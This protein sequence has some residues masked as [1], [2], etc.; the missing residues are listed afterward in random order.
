METSALTKSKLKERLA[1]L[2]F[3]RG[4]D[5]FCIVALEHIVYALRSALPEGSMNG[6][7]WYFE[8][9]EWEGLSP[10]DIIMPLFLFM[11]GVSVPFALGRHKLNG[12]G[13]PVYRRILRRFALLWIFGMIC[14]GN[15]LGL[16]PD[17]IYLYSN[18]LQAIAVGYLAST[19]IFLNF[20]W[21]TMVGIFVGLIAAFA[22]AMGMVRVG[23]YGGGDYT[24]AHNLAEWI[25]MQVLGR[26]RDGAEVVNGK[27]VVPSWNT[28]TWI[29]SSLTFMATTLSGTLC[30]MVLKS[31]A[32]ASKRKLTII[33]ASG[34]SM[35][36]AAY[37]ASALGLP[38][39][40]R[41]WTS[42]FVLVSSGWCLLLMGGLY[43]WIDMKGHKRGL[44][45]LTIYGTNSITAYMLALC[46]SFKSIVSS[47]FFGTE[48]II[49]SGWY[50]VV[51]AVGNA[52]IIYL[53]LRAMYRKGIFLK[54]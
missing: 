35:I 44:T 18:T 23:E 25:D 17:H 53:I 33:L 50:G 39:I 11:S 32:L 16:D 42:S 4:A 36:V 41:I 52:A 14:Q 30:G 26:F 20:G 13:W 21:R 49:G 3:L 45:F 27:V 46:V 54:V 8:H 22:L 29:L 43:W 1:S 7:M 47:I 34:I 6:V 5:L 9:V 37:A 48:H 31:K 15:L 51:L 40:K 2:D 24:Q 10:W 19:I 12:A 38:I 28:Y